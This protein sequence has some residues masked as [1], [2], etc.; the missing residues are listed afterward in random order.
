[1]YPL[2]TNPNPDPDSSPIEISNVVMYS[3]ESQYSMYFSLVR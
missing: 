1:M 2:L 3:M